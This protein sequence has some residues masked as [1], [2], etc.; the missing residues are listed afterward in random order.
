MHARDQIC[1][2]KLL[3]SAGEIDLGGTNWPSISFTKNE[4]EE[5]CAIEC[6]AR[7]GCTHYMWFDDK[8][9]R[10]QTSCSQMIATTAKNFICKKGIF[11]TTYFSKY[12]ILT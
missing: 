1:G 11:N 5:A 10:T 6:N 9:C 4:S 12:Y 7:S 3:G 2:T 8:G